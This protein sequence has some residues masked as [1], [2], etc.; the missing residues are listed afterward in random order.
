MQ[1]LLDFKQSN[2]NFEP[3]FAGIH[4]VLRETWLLDINFKLEISVKF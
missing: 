4:E 1:L 3:S 2:L